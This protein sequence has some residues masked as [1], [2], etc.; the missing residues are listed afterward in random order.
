[1][2]MM[3]MVVMMMIDRHQEEYVANLGMEESTQELSKQHSKWCA[4]A[5]VVLASKSGNTL[6]DITK[7]FGCGQR[8]LFQMQKAKHLM[9]WKCANT[10][11]WP[12]WWGHKPLLDFIGEAWRHL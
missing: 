10:R 2:V 4:S 7:K 5:T 9:K 11:D 3:M 12:G 6:E 8:S 1:M